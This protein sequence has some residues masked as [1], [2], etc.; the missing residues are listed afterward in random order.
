MSIKKM[1]TIFLG[2]ILACFSAAIIYGTIAAIMD[3]S[4]ESALEVPVESK[5]SIKED[6]LGSTYRK[7]YIDSCVAE[8]D[9]SYYD[10]C[11]CTYDYFDDTLTNTEFEV[12]V[13]DL[14]DDDTMSSKN[15]AIFDEAVSKCLSD[16]D[17][18]EVTI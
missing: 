5:K 11:A 7:I 10:Y 15:Q 13:S 12:F 3:G 2:I 17:L 6:K 8:G 14:T 16:V 18:T 4:D 1:L 9:S